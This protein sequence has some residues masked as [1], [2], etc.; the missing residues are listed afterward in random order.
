LKPRWLFLSALVVLVVIPTT[1]LALNYFNYINGTRSKIVWERTGGFIGLNEKLI[2]SA[3]KSILY[4]S[5]HFNDTEGVITKAEFEDLLNKAEFFT[6]DRYYTVK[7]NA[8]DYF[9]YKLTVETTSSTKTIEWVDAWASE[10]TLP[11]ELVEIQD[12]ILS[13]IESIHQEAKA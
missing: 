9:A 8:A 1:S 7:P 12:Q 4:L 10:E 2:I 13:I 3:D 11:P 5:N 6:T